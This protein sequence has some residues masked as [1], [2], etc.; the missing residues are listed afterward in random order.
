MLA[1][2]ETILER[3]Q[4]HNPHADVALLRRAYDFA[5]LK[6]TGQFRKSG[7]PYIIHPVAV[8]Q[9]LAELEMDEA[10]ISAGFL[11]DV[12]EDCGVTHDEIKE[13]FSE[14]IAQL[15]DGVTKLKLADFERLA[16]EMAAAAKEAA[17]K[18]AETGKVDPR[19][20]KR[21]ETHSSAEN[22]RKILLA[23][24]R[25]FRV[26]VIKLADRL[27]NM[28]TLQGLSPERQQRVAEETMQIFAPLAHRLGIWQ[29]KWQLEDLA[30]KY[31]YPTE[32][33]ELSER[34]ARTR[35]EREDDIREAIQK[36]REG[37]ARAGLTP[38]I[39]GRP[40]H[41]WSIYNKMV[42]QGLELTDIYD[43]IA[44]RV[45]TPTIPECYGA[46][47][48]IH[49]T[50]LP[51]PGKF[52]DYIA[53]RKANLYQS[54]HTK[55]YGPRGEP[56]EVQ[57]R[58]WEMHKTA[59]FGVAAHW[60]YKERGEE[61][62]AGLD[63]F[64]RKMAFLRAQLFDAHQA[65]A[66]PGEFLSRA[67]S[68]LFAD[69][70][71]VFT[72]K[73]DVLDLPAGATPIDFAYRVHSNVG[74][75]LVQAKVNGR[76]VNLSYKLQNGDICQVL[77]RP[78][79]TPSLD[80]LMFARSGHARGK[81]KN[82]FRKLKYSDNVVQGRERLM[83][84][85]ERLGLSTAILRESKKMLSLANTLNKESVDDL[86]AALGF[87]D[88]A[89]GMVV[90]RLRPELEKEKKKTGEDF[91]RPR[92]K[93]KLAL[94][95]GGVD[96]VAVTRG[97]CCLPLPGDEVLGY[98]SRGRGII[99]H[100]EGCPNV[101]AYEAERLSPIDWQPSLTERFETG[102]IIET[103]DR[104]GLLRDVTDFFSENKVFILGINTRSD[105]SKGIAVLRL[106]FEAPSAEYVE[107]L[108][109]KL[110]S[111]EDLLAVHRL[112]VGAEDPKP[113]E[114]T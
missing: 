33:K 97:R 80:W 62:R 28:R 109:R 7:E 65:E 112:G 86:F 54:L 42:K 70:V 37:F 63:A 91:S 105:R 81:I 39:Q 55:V 59:E 87:G 1:S 57:I 58:T 46:L 96:G 69:Q 110:H 20:R 92:A 84:E 88:V 50:Y 99:L 30:F 29:V 68:D 71:F 52:D 17:A 27:H 40:K 74:D 21:L 4:R 10:S 103:F 64:E 9:I 36:L 79:A 43:L 8:A 60:A 35:V 38:D 100:R 90:N 49:E 5:T 85:L 67:S 61:A 26:M 113:V 41:L 104:T 106:D 48:V 3:V 51:I 114:R 32:Y 45:I 77:T 108:V 98:V 44:L 94:A 47:G 107:A 19:R 111:L 25:D 31:L 11:H 101:A 13:H 22:L 12:V 82:Y 2:L 23:T 53:K 78:Q 34:I 72:P 56:L 89:L 15:V 95:P 76:V 18:E 75:H 16:P 73:G 24:A 93:E 6:H 102:M 14:E 66:N 83:E